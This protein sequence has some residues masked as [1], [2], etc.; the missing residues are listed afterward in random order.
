VPGTL[1]LRGGVVHWATART[2]FVCVCVC[3]WDQG[4]VSF[5]TCSQKRKHERD[6]IKKKESV[7]ET[8]VDWEIVV[9]EFF[10]PQWQDIAEAEAKEKKTSVT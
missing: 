8:L 3:V 9:R 4:R 1:Q 6:A 10:V 5:F 7:E 2:M